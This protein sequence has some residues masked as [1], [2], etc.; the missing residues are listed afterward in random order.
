MR[1]DDPPIAFAELP[2]Q[3]QRE[4]RSDHAGETGAVCI[5]KGIL[6]VSRDPEVRAFSEA[7]M[8]T[9]REHLEFFETWMPKRWHTRLTGLWRVAGWSLGALSALF[10]SRAV[11]ATIRAVESFV[12]AHYAEQIRML[13]P[14][15][16]WNPL[17]ERLEAFRSDELE[18]RDD[19]ARRLHERN[20]IIARAWARVVET[21]S[22]AGVI[23]ARRL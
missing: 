20:G 12:D 19:A 23:A 5:Y 9:E 21:G 17:R 18:H 6:A 1:H 4:I 14:N 8:A 3:L 16:H 10:G 11:F 22:A 13:E 7:H 15:P 2:R